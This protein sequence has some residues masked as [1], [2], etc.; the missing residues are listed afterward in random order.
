[1]FRKD[2]I[3]FVGDVTEELANTAKEIYPSATLIDRTNNCSLSNGVYYTSIGEFDHPEQFVKI[4]K[5]ATQIIYSPPNKWSDSING[6]SRLRGHTV[7]YLLGSVDKKIIKNISLIDNQINDLAEMT[8]LADI[9]KTNDSQLWLAGCSFTEGVGV[10]TN[11]RYGQLISDNLGMPVSFLALQGSSNSW[12][13]DQ[14]LRSDVRAGDIVIFGITQWK[15]FSYYHNHLLQHI[16][17]PYYVVNP[18][19]KKVVSIDQLDSM[20]NIY[21]SVTAIERAINFCHKV[22]AK[23]YLA[24]LLCDQKLKNFVGHHRTF[25]SL[26]DNFLD[27]GYDKIHPG[28]ITHQWYADTLLEKIKND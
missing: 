24:G 8:H 20:N 21:L 6:F 23:I 27:L 14:I 26:Y 1:M 28:P 17:P 22:G 3:I 16:N 13:S 18:E 19:F 25:V 9:R 10:T 11:Q 5:Q 15:R 7:Y 2:I 12:I 4:I